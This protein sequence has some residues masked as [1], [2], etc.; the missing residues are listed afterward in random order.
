MSESEILWEKNMQALAKANPD[1]HTALQNLNPSKY[2]RIVLPNG[3]HD[4]LNGNT[5]LYGDDPEAYALE[6]IR[7]SRRDHPKLIV[8]YGFGLG[9]ILK[10]LLEDFGK[11]ACHILVVEHDLE[12]I[13]HSFHTFDWSQETAGIRLEWF[14]ALPLDT[15]E[16]DLRE[17]MSKQDRFMFNKTLL[18]IYDK[19]SLFLGQEYYLKFS[20]K[21]KGAIDYHTKM[22]LLPPGEDTYL[23]FTNTIENF[24]SSLTVPSFHHMNDLFKGFPGIL[25]S[26]GPSLEKHFDF[27][28]SINDRAIVICADSA[29]RTLVK[30]GIRPHF[31]CTLERVTETKYFFSDLPPLPDTWLLL[32]PIIWPE[33][34]SG[35][36]GPRAHLMRSIAQANY[37]W[38][39]VPAQYTGNSCSHVGLVALR[40]MGCD[41]ILLLG[42]DFAFDRFSKKTHAGEQPA[43][44][45]KV[46][47][48]VREQAQESVD[49]GDTQWMVEGNNGEKILTSHWLRDFQIKTEDILGKMSA[50]CY[51]VIPVEYGAKIRHTTRIDPSNAPALLGESREIVSVIRKHLSMPDEREQKEKHLFLRDQVHKA[52][53]E[54]SML[55][56]LSLD[57]MAS[58]SSY[59]NQFCPDFYPPDFYTP[60]LKKIDEVMDRLLFDKSREVFV[61]FFGPQIQETYLTLTVLSH[62]LLTNK[63]KPEQK[64]EKQKDYIYQM[65]RTIHYWSSRMH[66]FLTTHQECWDPD[67]ATPSIQSNEERP[68]LHE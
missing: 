45:A 59:F 18:P 43:V 58:F 68:T 4:L 15:V 34:Y 16:A 42:Q 13:W 26:T 52:L 38:P 23:A 33:T 60:Y 57:M 22:M 64:L 39:E 28:R 6:A 19:V 55:Q 35:Y 24:R 37:F 1:L 29:I 36:P 56:A 9:Y 31:I 63:L 10:N 25:V 8:L 32:T 61:N 30:N 50:K 14:V 47:G 67:V 17:Y 41:P 2:Q 20:E 44:I 65:F 27:L 48:K 21:L 7:E 49:S 3:K 12:L 40:D 66:H 51:N 5:R 53:E 11:E 62:E 54:L 46:E